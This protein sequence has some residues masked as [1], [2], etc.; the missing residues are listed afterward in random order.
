MK[1]ETITV[2]RRQKKVIVVNPIP[3]TPEDKM[4]LAHY[5]IGNMKS[6]LEKY[7]DNDLKDFY[8]NIHST[9][10]LALCITASLYADKDDVI[11]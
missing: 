1:E 4:N 11:E 2:N 8:T 3:F 9:E 10:D 6:H 7:N 5:H